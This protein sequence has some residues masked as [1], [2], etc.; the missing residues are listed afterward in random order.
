MFYFLS[1]Q[2]DSLSDPPVT[3]EY[4]SFPIPSITPRLG[5]GVESLIGRINEKMSSQVLNSLGILNSIFMNLITVLKFLHP[6]SIFIQILNKCS[7][8]KTFIIRVQIIYEENTVVGTRF[9][10]V[11]VFRN[12]KVKSLKF[13]KNKK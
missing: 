1:P 3:N 7:N 2:S 6:Y 9:C 10:K 4:S 8:I 11:H 5:E 12:K 13:H